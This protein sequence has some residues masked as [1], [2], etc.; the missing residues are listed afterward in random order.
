MAM[1]AAGGATGATAGA[2]AAV[3]NAQRASGIFVELAPEQ[4]AQF[5]ARPECQV[6]V[7]AEYGFWKWKKLL[8]LAPYK[9][10]AFYTK[11]DAP[12]DLPPDI[13]VVVAEKIQIPGVA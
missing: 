1:C 2:A 9:G 12:L 5:L 13:E 6:V 4:L 7:L 8:H 3:V 11:A 10:L